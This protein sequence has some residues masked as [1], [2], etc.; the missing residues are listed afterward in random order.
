MKRTE[1]TISVSLPQNTFFL[2]LV[3]TDSDMTQSHDPSLHHIKQDFVRLWKDTGKY[4]SCKIPPEIEAALSN[5]K[6]TFL[7]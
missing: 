7:F 1:T 2:Y 3:F 5:K 4:S 6:A